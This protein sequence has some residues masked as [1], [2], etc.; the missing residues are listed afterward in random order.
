MGRHNADSGPSEQRTLLLMLRPILKLDVRTSGSNVEFHFSRLPPL[1]IGGQ[2]SVNFSDQD[3]TILM[4][5][6]LGNGH[7]INTGHY[8]HR[9]KMMTAVVE[10]E[11]PHGRSLAGQQKRLPERFGGTIGIPSP[12]RWE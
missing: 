8:T 7:V 12:R 4:A 9:N 1:V 5:H 11:A 3:S 6:P 2:M 10:A